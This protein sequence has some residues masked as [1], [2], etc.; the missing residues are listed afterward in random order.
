MNDYRL[1]LDLGTNS[2]G[3]CAL[4]LKKIDGPPRPVSILDMGVRIFPDGRNPKDG[5]SN[6]EARRKPRGMRRNRDRF[7]ERRNKLLKDLVEYGLMPQDET[8]RRA[9]TA[10]DPYEL[11][12]RGAEESLT[13]YEFGRA[14][15][16]LNQRRGFKSNRKSD[17]AASDAGAI[18]QAVKE[19]ETQIDAAGVK[20]FG[21]YLYKRGQEGKHVRS[22]LKTREVPGSGDRTKNE[23]YYEFYPSREVLDKEFDVLWENQKQHHPKILTDEARAVIHKIIFYQRPL[24]PQVVGSCTFELSEERAPKALPIVQRSRIYQELNN[25]QI[26]DTTLQSRPLT[27]EERD[28][29][30]DMLCH[31]GGKKKGKSELTFQKM[32]KKLK[33][34]ENTTFS[35]ESEKRTTLEAD[36]TSALMVHVD[37]FGGQWYTMTDE[38][39]EKVI[40]A[41][42]HE[43]DEEKLIQSLMETWGVDRAHAETISA[44]SLPDGHGRLGRTASRKIVRELVNEVIPYSEAVVRAGYK[45]H[46][47]LSHDEALDRLPYYGVV[48][49]RHVVLDPEK[50]GH[51]AAPLELRYGKVSN[52]TVHIAMNQLRKVVNE[53][54]KIHG[55]P[56]EIHVE[57]LRDLKNSLKQK[58][59]M[60]KVQKT[61]QD[62]NDACRKELEAFG[63]RVNRENIQR[64]RLWREMP[65]GNRCCVYTGETIC[66][67]KLFSEEVEIDHILPFSKTWDDG[68]ANKVLC[69]RNANRT[70]SN[71]SPYE[72][73]GKDEQWGDILSRSA[74]LPKNKR[75]RFSEDA[76]EQWKEEG[77]FLARQLTDSQYIA[78]LAREYLSTLFPPKKTFKV[79]CLPGKLTGLFRKHLGLIDILDKVNPSRKEHD[80]LR[81]EKNRADHRH[82]AMDAL[83]V[84]CMD[85]DFLQEAAYIK[86]RFE[87]EGVY[88]LLAGLEEPWPN[89]HS[90]AREALSKIIVSHKLD[91]GI[92]GQLHR[93]T[94]YGYAKREDPRG[95]A[96][97]RVPVSSLT[98]KNLQ[99]I[100][101]WGLRAALLAHLAGIPRTEAADIL[102]K[103]DNTTRRATKNLTEVCGLK[104]KSEKEAAKE[105]EKRIQS[106]CINR[107]I[108]RVRLIEEI[109]LKP[110][111]D[112]QGRKY[113]G[114]DPGGNAYLDILLSEDGKKWEEKLVTRFDAHQEIRGTNSAQCKRVVRLFNHD[115]VEIVHEGKRRIFYIQSMSKKIIALTEHFEA[116]ADSRNRDKNDPFSFVYKGVEP[117]RKS[118]VRFLKVSPAGRIRYLSDIADDTSGD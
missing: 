21:A 46:S 28:T 19:L 84:G 65:A 89:F 22:R 37:R 29:L 41:L 71:S 81:G 42:I 83:V 74:L 24:K 13:P 82:H 87:E 97:H 1:A 14:L 38:D 33:L 64:M 30:A 63:Q 95:N 43:S 58:Q 59:E 47:Q 48:L 61:N 79:V 9:L 86:A 96:I 67:T 101:G 54:I 20:T 80:A 4:T 7:L 39:K 76:M 25:L 113:K 8:K 111:R 103:L 109:T 50:G 118:K 31:P 77:G 10:L 62:E 16:H 36:H 68:M 108:R 73:W 40:D 69:M 116:N 99:F 90:D 26:I 107:G 15:F 23:D 3:W 53:I 85:K 117:L 49:E 94:A 106:F 35:H 52:P 56:A 27:L 32:R 91:H 78:K 72:R 5:S 70:K 110:I 98:L 105:I 60:Q 66:K 115:M 11:R 112:R 17:A 92:A 88:R 12:A 6:A 57:V 75:W 93:E 100:K 102:E 55:K 45:S 114:F 18:K 34:G 2:I 51:P 44:T 104:G